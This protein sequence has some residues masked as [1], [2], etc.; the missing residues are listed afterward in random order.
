MDVLLVTASPANAVKAALE[1][2]R[3]ITLAL[4]NLNAMTKKQS[5]AE[6]ERLLEWGVPD[7][8]ITYRCPW[9]LP[10]RIFQRTRRGAYNIHPS[11]LPKYPGKNPWDDNFRHHEHE[12]GVTLH[13]LTEQVDAGPIV[14]QTPFVIE[15]SETLDSARDKADGIAAELVL[16][17]CRLLD[18]TVERTLG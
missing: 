7:L 13:H 14:F 17:L 1:Q 2:Q 16:R 6:I 11:L 8:L 3:Q 15:D 10:K 12:S 4:A 18:E 9:I 5:F